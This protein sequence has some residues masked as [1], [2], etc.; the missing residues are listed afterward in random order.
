MYIP[1]HKTSSEAKMF[2][3]GFLKQY[4]CA[5]I[6]I[7]TPWQKCWNEHPLWRE[8]DPPSPPPKQCCARINVSKDRARMCLAL[9]VSIQNWFGGRGLMK[10]YLFNYL[11]WV[12]H[13][14]SIVSTNFVNDCSISYSK[15]NRYGIPNWQT[16]IN[17]NK[18][19]NRQTE[20][21]TGRQTKTKNQADKMTDGGTN[22]INALILT[23][24]E[25]WIW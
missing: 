16:D 15:V 19:A 1:L 4:I 22:R 6:N 7:K 18:Q 23:V 2:S 13:F 10:R 5:V 3:Y 12:I 25:L 21:Y 8:V 24:N 9:P 17:I 14:C 11:Y 20:K